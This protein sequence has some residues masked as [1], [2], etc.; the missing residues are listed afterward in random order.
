[1]IFCHKIR[2]DEILKWTISGL[3]GLMHDGGEKAYISAC[4]IVK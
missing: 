4:R 1:M 2:L 3:G